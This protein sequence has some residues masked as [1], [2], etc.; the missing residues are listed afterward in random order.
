MVKRTQR[1][2]W[3]L[4]KGMVNMKKSLITFVLVISLLLFAFTGC[5]ETTTTIDI[6]QLYDSYTQY[7]PEMVILEGDDMMNFY[8][9]DETK[10]NAAKIAV[11]SDG[12]RSDE[13]WLVEAVDETAAAEIYDLANGR[14]EREAEETKNYAPDQYAVVEKAQVILDGNYVVLIISPDV[15]TMVS[16]FNEAK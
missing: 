2:C 6:E 10:C 14:V 8:G 4:R 13:V 11:C 7:L 15:D 3:L 16:L 1:L 5:S 12:L 9:V